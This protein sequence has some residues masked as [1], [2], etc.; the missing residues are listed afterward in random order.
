MNVLNF[1]VKNWDFILLIVA[2]LAAVIFAIFKGNK[3]VVMRMLY[4][5][6][7]EAEQ[8]YGA[9]TGSL[10]L[11]AVIDT[12]YPN[13]PAVIKLFITDKT[14]VKWVEEALKAAK[15]AWEKNSAIA[16]YVKKPAENAQNDAQ[17]VATAP[18]K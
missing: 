1:I 11:A 14:L 15:E 2:A 8:F 16:E 10:K 5:L 18:A 7:T 3:S 17:S 12:I 13:L 9:G 4:S 6:V